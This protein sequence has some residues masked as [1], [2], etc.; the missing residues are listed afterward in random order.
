MFGQN[1]RE[2]KIIAV[3]IVVVACIG[4]LVAFTQEPLNI[5]YQMNLLY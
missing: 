4:A 5:H 2:L 3:V 1:R